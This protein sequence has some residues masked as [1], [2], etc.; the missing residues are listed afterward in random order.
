M[1]LLK[2]LN[3]QEERVHALEEKVRMLQSSKDEMT[4]HATSQS[5]T[6][7]ELQTKNA[8]LNIENEALKRKADSLQQVS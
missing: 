3:I 6:I 8:N 7:S 2:N 1:K 5:H 4:S